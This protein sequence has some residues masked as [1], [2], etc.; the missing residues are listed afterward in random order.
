MYQITIRLGPDDSSADTVLNMRRIVGVSRFIIGSYR[1][2]EFRRIRT[3]KIQVDHVRT[4][5]SQG[6]THEDWIEFNELINGWLDILYGI[7][8]TSSDVKSSSYLVRYR[9]QARL[10]YT[11]GDY[12]G[13]NDK[14]SQK[15]AATA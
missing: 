4:S 8:G 10:T 13:V 3:L 14:W 9:N 15:P 6:M 12:H 5:T 7:D 11:P 2:E 1:T